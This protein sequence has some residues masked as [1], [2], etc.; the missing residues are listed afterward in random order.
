V[1]SS[2]SDASAPACVRLDLRHLP[3]V[4][5][6]AAEYAHD[7]GALE[8]FFAGNPAERSAWA[9]AVQR[10]QAPV[11]DRERLAAA[12]AA[13]LSQR[14]APAAS[15]AALS[16]LRDP[17]GVAIVTGQQAGLFG[18]PLYS[19]LKA[20]T[21][22]QVARRV[23]QD[24]GVPAVPVFW[25]DSEDHDWREVASTTLLDADLAP[26]DIE[27]P[28]PAGA[29]QLPVA[30]LRLDESVGPVLERV[31][32]VLPHTEFTDELLASLA[33]AYAP[34]RTMAEAFGRW[35]ETWLGPLGLVVYD[36]ADPA[37][38][39]LATPVF[40]HELE[41]PARTSALAAEAGAALE[42]R[43]FHAQVSAHLDATALFHLDPERHP[44]KLTAGGF[45]IGSREVTTDALLAEVAGHPERF[46]PNVLLRPLVQD[47][48]FPTVA[49]VSGPSELAYLGQLRSVY[50]DFDIP[51]PLVVPR[52]TA[53]LLDAATA[54]FLD[55]YQLSFPS[56]QPQ[57]EST[58]NH[59]L[60]GQLPPGVESSF[61]QVHHQVVETMGALVAALPALDPTLEGAAR[62]TLGKMEHDLRTL[63][64]KI[65][66]AAKRR[67][68]T[69]RRQFTRARATTFPHG[70]LQERTLCFLYFLN[71]Y[72][73]ALIGVLDRH[74][75]PDG[76]HHCLLTV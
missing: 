42:A 45:R 29:G 13:Q 35:L 57:D 49:Y 28:A 60:E 64:S 36:C 38:K 33:L 58:L 61:Q 12:L 2:S 10:A 41:N 74:L 46:S 4:R 63:H 67:D 66:H 50:A 73:P 20:L 48:L 1:Q 8:P 65:I 18:G 39:P 16:A 37:A 30:N 34:G 9:A 71:R 14:E 47:A 43:G 22:I 62:S 72:G 54:R 56:L 11:R 59:L 7:F 44:I 27:L 53:T 40:R 26:Q 75:T 15:V 23:S 76:G 31:R 19:L 52:T 55:R 68:E 17:R 32:R 6:L 25:I 51:M 70:H 5:R 69:L 24:H 3:W 21:A